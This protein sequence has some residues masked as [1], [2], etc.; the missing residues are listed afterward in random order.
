MGYSDVKEIFNDVKQLANKIQNQELNSK[1]LDLQASMMELATENLD[2]R[3]KLLKV[4]NLAKFKNSLVRKGD[5]WV[6][7]EEIRS[8]ISSGEELD[9]DVIACIYCPVCLADDKVISVN[10]HLFDIGFDRELSCPVCKYQS[11]QY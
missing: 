6:K 8:K 7:N 3:D 9:D 5:F 10:N 4:D 11:S 2:M 1:I